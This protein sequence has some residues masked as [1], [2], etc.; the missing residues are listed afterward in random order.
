MS[1]ALI[2][3]ATAGLGAAFARQLAAAGNDL[4]LVA[5]DGKRLSDNA[6]ILARQ[7]SVDVSTLQ[8]DLTLDADCARVGE[9]AERVDLLVN[10]AGRALG[11]GFGHATLSDEEQL[12]DLNVRAVLRLTRVALPAMRER[13]HGAIVNVS[14]VAGVAPVMPGSTYNA[15][16]AWVTMFSESMAPIGRPDGVTVMALCPGFV[17]TEFHDRAN[18][19]MTGIPQW[20]MLDADFVVETALRDLRRGKLVSIPSMK[21]KLIV[22]ALRH[23]P[24]GLL[25]WGAQRTEAVSRRGRAK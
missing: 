5:R 11:K 3:G 18:I 7:Y 10:N 6:D 12:L 23:V 21:Y 20:M 14:S 9:A 13:G 8:A 1:T 4:I 19:D 16:K 25:S 24:N 2:T 15:S 22:S 17:Y